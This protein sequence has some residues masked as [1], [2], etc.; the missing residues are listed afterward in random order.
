MKRNEIKELHTKTTKE[1]WDLL[2]KLR[3][4]VQKLKIDLS[5]NKVGNTRSLS[6]KLDDIARIMTVLRTKELAK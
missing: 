1:L 4:D 5:Q 2:K 3:I 6:G